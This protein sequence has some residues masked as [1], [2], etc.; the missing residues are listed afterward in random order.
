MSVFIKKHQG[1]KDNRSDFYF[2]IVVNCMLILALTIVLYPLYFIVIAS[3]SDP[4]AVN[5]GQVLFLP[6]NIGFSCYKIIFR[7]RDIWQGYRNTIFYTVFGTLL[8]LSVSLPAAYSLSRSDL[9]GRG[10]IMKYFVLTMFFGGGLI[11]T[12]LVVKSL[13]LTNTPFV[14]MILGSVSVYNII[15]AKTFFESTIPKELLEAASID[16]CPNGKFFFRIV[17]PLSK[18]IVAVVTLTYAISHWNSFFNGLI[19]LSNQSLYPLQLVL[20]EILISSQLVQGENVDPDSIVELM[21]VAGT[22]KY[23]VIIVSSLPVLIIYPFLQKYFTKG[24]MIG[25]IKG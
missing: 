6:K 9:I 20:R 22:I 16:G 10:W 1:I 23:G 21:R 8:G 25:S 14:M 17:L 19:Y 7:D 13:H 4:N 5:N 18:P 2:N 24:I 11:P 3:I 15:V 12:Y